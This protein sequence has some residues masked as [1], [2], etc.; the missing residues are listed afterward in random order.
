MATAETRFG[1]WLQ[2]RRIGTLNHRD[3]YTWLTLADEYVDDPRREVLGLVFE[4]NL[5]ARHAAT[6][7]L[8]NWFSNLLPEGRLR[9]LIAADSGV[10]VQ[11]EMELL[12][13]VGHDL[14]GAVRI[15]WED[16]EPEP[17]EAPGDAQ[18]ESPSVQQ[19]AW[20]FSLAGVAIKFSMIR[21]SDKLRLPATGLGGDW[22]VKLPDPM[23][24][25][26]PQNEFA[27][28]ELAA[29]AG[30]EVPERMLVPRENLEALPENVWE[31]RE[32]VAYAVKR[33]DRRP[34]GSLVH[35]E[36]LAQVRNFHAS[37]KYVG[38]FESV[39]AFVFRGLDEPSLHEF[40]RRLTFNILISNGDAH[41]KNWSLFY[42][43]PRR[44]RLSPAYDLVSTAMY[45]MQLGQGPET[46]ALKFAGSRKFEAQRVSHFKSLGD[47]LSAD[48]NALRDVAVETIE[49]VQ[50]AWDEVKTC[51]DVAPEVQ[52]AVDRS[53][54]A[55]TSTLLRRT[56]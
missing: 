49:R 42:E 39:A 21:R 15:L 29:S 51:L 1:V 56:D 11:R 23:Y 6:L 2:D 10:S 31:S 55:R 33:F 44:P 7:R 3:D 17:L 16:E 24:R 40:V 38:T 45:A 36:D 30:L 54:R 47:R 28:M 12:A 8:P 43:D 46:M 50:E 20:R 13:H 22:I 19:Q 25:H 14:P 41:L 5:H 9:D 37:K 48:G 52:D 34:D 18:P 35:M 4:D 53:I 26:V 27:M 32:D